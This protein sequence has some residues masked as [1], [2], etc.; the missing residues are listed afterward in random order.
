MGV[1]SENILTSAI[2][3][4]IDE[5][6]AEE[7]AKFGTPFSISKAITKDGNNASLTIGFS[8]DPK[9]S[10]DNLIS[11]SGTQNKEG[12]FTTYS[13]T[14]QFVCKGVNNKEKFANARTAWINEQPLYQDKI[15]R[16]FHPLIDFFEKNR[17]TNFEKTKGS[18]S[19][20]VTFT[21][22]SAYHTDEDGLLKF[23]KT[24]SKTHQINRIE[25][26]L[27]INGLK[28]EV[29]VSDKRTVGQA[30]VTAEA[31]VSQSMGIYKAQEILES[32]TPE[33]ND[34]VD[35]DVIHIIKDVVSLNLGQ[36]TATRKLDYLFLSS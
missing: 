26:Y 20:T 30:S 14:I 23:K 32:K 8:T 9:K 13:L 18:I 34:L 29:V 35:E 33:L 28:D 15:Q 22:D 4:I 3:I 25:K 19:E 12:K 7:E 17:S 1:D 31:T 16:L 24:L 11:Y 27:N 21:T 10:Q 36:G 2:A 5:K 6:K